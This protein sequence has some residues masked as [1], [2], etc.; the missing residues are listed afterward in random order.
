MTGGGGV[1]EAFPGG[2]KE[3][4]TWSKLDPL[5]AIGTKRLDEMFFPKIPVVEPTP[6][7]PSPTPLLSEETQAA[8]SKARRRKQGRRRNILAGR[9][10]AGR[11]DILNT[12]SIK[13]LGE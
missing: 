8:K 3:K 1:Y 5:S 10:M 2:K 13:K 4:K 9:M 6:L 11:R 7:D 12:Q